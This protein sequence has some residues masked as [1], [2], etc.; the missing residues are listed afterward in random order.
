MYPVL[1]ILY[2]YETRSSLTAQGVEPTNTENP[3][4]DYMNCGQPANSIDFF[5]RSVTA[6]SSQVITNSTQWPCADFA[7]FFDHD[8]IRHNA[9][10]S[11]PVFLDYRCAVERQHDFSEV[12][13]IYDN[14]TTS[15]V[16]GAI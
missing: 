8:F 1:Y 6:N 16:S 3:A 10:Y 13:M 5:S 4:M 9:S 7:Y 11:I 14:E 15:L 2:Q 12:Q